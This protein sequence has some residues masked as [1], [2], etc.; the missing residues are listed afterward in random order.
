MRKL[1]IAGAMALTMAATASW[2]E[3]KIGYINSELI[4]MEYEGTKD[5]QDK[6]NKEVAKWEQEASKKQKEIKD[7]KDQ[8]DKQSLLL[9]NDRKKEMEDSLNQKMISYQSFLQEKFGQKGE[10]LVKNEELT[11][12]I[13]EKIN[14]II[15]KIAKEENYDYIFDARAGGIVFAKKI[16]DLND[17]V[18]AQL[19]KEK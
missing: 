13:I 19:S 1:M 2:A 9:S 5:A 12:P 11:K 6:F 7:L 18:L 10:A 17:R 14:K 15:E 16:Y 4:F 8:L 3:L